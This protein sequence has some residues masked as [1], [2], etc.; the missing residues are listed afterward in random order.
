LSLSSIGNE[1]E[2]K[3]TACLYASAPHR[4]VTPGHPPPLLD[5]RSIG[6]LRARSLLHRTVVGSI[7]TESGRGHRSCTSDV[8]IRSN[9]TEQ[10]RIRR[11]QSAQGHRRGVDRVSC[12]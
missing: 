4:A 5:R 6:L 3:G 9:E 2:I 1:P 7:D 10:R 8:Y 12:G 11:Q